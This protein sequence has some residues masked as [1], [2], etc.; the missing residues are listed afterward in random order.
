MQ[1]SLT[2]TKAASFTP[3][4][5]VVQVAFDNN[6]QTGGLPL[7]ASDLGLDQGAGITVVPMSRKGYVFSYDPVNAKL[8]AFEPGSL[9]APDIE[10][11]NGTDLSTLTGVWVIAFGNPV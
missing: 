8:Q 9:N 3:G 5:R 11:G 7:A 1:M 4:M 6:Y 10:V 2:I